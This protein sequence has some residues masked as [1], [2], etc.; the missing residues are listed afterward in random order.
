[1]G[2]WQF[3]TLV[4]FSSML[5]GTLGHRVSLIEGIGVMICLVLSYEEGNK[6]G[7]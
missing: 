1:M 2:K 6:G 7:K 3:M 4:L 5:L